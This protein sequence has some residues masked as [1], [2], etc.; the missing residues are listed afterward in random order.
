MRVY[1]DFDGTIALEDVTDLVL[2][3]LAHPEWEQVED[4]W[5]RG[6]IDS[7]ECMSRQVAMISAEKSDLDALLDTVEIDPGFPAFAA[8]CANTH[9]PLAVVSDGVDYFISRI[10]ARFGLERLPVFANRL[11]FEKQGYSLASPFRE[12]ACLTGSGVCKCTVVG[13]AAP[14]L[15]Y[16]GDGRSDRCVS[17]HATLLFAK[18]SL[19][20][21]CETQGRAFLPFATFHDVRAHVAGVVSELDRHQ[22]KGQTARL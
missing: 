5:I 15:V 10:L 8:W 4:A 19:A 21:F 3:N 6:D 13:G 2:R 7:R 17:A 18:D 20:E 12:P 14:F 1:S 9:I 22:A 16:V 11:V